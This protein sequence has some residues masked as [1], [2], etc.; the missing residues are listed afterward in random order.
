MIA[1][2]ESLRRFCVDEVG[3]PAAKVEVVHYGLDAL[4]EPWGDNAG[5]RRCRTARASC[6]CVS[7]LEEQKGVDVAVRALARVREVEP[8]G[9]AGRP[10]RRARSARELAGEGVYLPGRVGDVAAWYRAGGA[11]RPPGALGGL[12]ARGARGDARREAGGRRR[13][14]ARSRSS[15]STARPGCSSRR[16]TPAAL[17][18]ALLAV[19][20]DPARAA[21]MGEAGLARARAEFSVAQMAERTPRSTRRS[22]AVLAP[23]GQA[24]GAAALVEDLRPVDAALLEEVPQR[25]ARGRRRPSRP[26]AAGR[27]PGGRSPRAAARPRR[28]ATSRPVSPSRTSSPRPP[29]SAAITGRARSIASSATM[30]KPSPIEGTTTIAERSI[31]LWIGAT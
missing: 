17:A 8:R 6:S 18:E 7:R 19:L 22:A 14:S 1:I 30:P 15:S 24:V 3:L 12:R 21:A 5:G 4:P 10:R 2:T 9:G 25:P 27:P 31:A 13:G 16:T 29:I 20:G 28:A 23:A 26:P 11:P